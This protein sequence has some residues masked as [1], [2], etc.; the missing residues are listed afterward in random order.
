MMRNKF[1]LRAKTKEI[2]DQW[3]EALEFLC[4]VREK[5]GTMSDERSVSVATYFSVDS[6]VDR[7]ASVTSQDV[8][9]SKNSKSYKYQNLGKEE[10]MG[11]MNDDQIDL[12]SIDKKLSQQKKQSEEIIEKTG[13]WNY[14]SKIPEKKLKSRV[15]YGFLGKP[16]RGAIKVEK[17]RWLFLISSRP[18][19]QDQYLEDGEQ[20]TDDDLPPL[21]EFDTIYYYSTGIN[22]DEINLAGEIKSL[23]IDKVYINSENDSNIHSFVID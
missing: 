15:M 12:S 1:E 22:N 23:D 8:K 6:K 20:I 5:L 9:G 11:I 3:V 13:I 19:N 18:L 21:V 17:M 2:R 7:S 4:D 10:V 14:I 16:T